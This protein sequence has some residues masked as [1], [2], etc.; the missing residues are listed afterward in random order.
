MDNAFSYHNNHTNI[1]RESVSL[2]VCLFVRS[3][4]LVSCEAT[5]PTPDINLLKKKTKLKPKKND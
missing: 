4:K 3:T 1:Q 5:L 2:F